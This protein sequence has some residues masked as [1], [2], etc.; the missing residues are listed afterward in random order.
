MSKM[1]SNEVP[2]EF[3]VALC[4]WS[5]QYGNGQERIT[6]LNSEG[7]NAEHIQQIVNLIGAV[8]EECDY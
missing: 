1:I 2:E 3:F 6:K 5:G 8:F 7:Y 4:V